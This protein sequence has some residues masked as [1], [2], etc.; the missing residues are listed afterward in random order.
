MFASLLSPPEPTQSPPLDFEVFSG[1]VLKPALK[2]TPRRDFVHFRVGFIEEAGADLSS[3]DSSDN[4][5]N[6]D[7]YNKPEDSLKRKRVTFGRELSPE[8]FDR[9]LPADTPLRRGST[10]YNHHNIAA[11]PYA[12]QS[13]C[14]SP[15]DPLPQPDFDDRDQ[16]ETLQPLSLCFDAESSDSDSPASSSLPDHTDE[17]SPNEE[18]AAV[19]LSASTDH[20]PVTSSKEMAEE[21]DT[22]VSL[23]DADIVNES[24]IAPPEVSTTRIR[25][26][27]SSEKPPSSEETLESN[28]LKTLV[29]AK[30]K[31][32]AKKT[33]KPMIIRKAQMKAPRGKGKK[34]GG[35]SKKSVQK[36]VNNERDG[37]S[38][39]PLL[40][41]IPELPE[42]VPTPPATTSGVFP[43]GKASKYLVKKVRTQASA[44]KVHFTFA[45]SVEGNLEEKDTERPPLCVEN[46]PAP[47]DMKGSN[48][49]S[50]SEDLPGSD[51]VDLAPQAEPVN[52]ECPPSLA[53]VEVMDQV[54]KPATSPVPS[55]EVEKKTKITK[56]RS[57]TRK[58]AARAPESS[59]RVTSKVTVDCVRLDEDADHVS[60]KPTAS[61][62]DPVQGAVAPSS[63]SNGLS[64]K[65]TTTSP[66]KPPL[67][68]ISTDR[69][70]SRRSSRIHQVSSLLSANPEQNPPAE[71]SSAPVPYLAEHSDSSMSDFCL[72]IDEALQ[73]PQQEKKVRRSMRL[74][75]DSGV[76]GLSWVEEIKGS[77][78]TGRRRSLSSVMRLEESSESSLDHTV[79]SPNKENLSNHHVPNLARRT[80]RRTLGTTTIQEGLLT[81]DTKRRRS[82]SS[83]KAPNTTATSDEVPHSALV[84][85]A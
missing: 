69:K 21:T 77:D 31:L 42:C 5:E 83:H 29:I 1:P 25:T 75:R 62:D 43:P 79:H 24:F 66:S 72:P 81:C 39:R 15:C 23:S 51:A 9:T 27:R 12:Q 82:I 2:K 22:S 56:R 7:I 20:E 33:R 4:G 38:K 78:P 57:S 37:I 41:P 19:N 74:R 67:G 84:P 68:C 8:L 52:S 18:E 10:P 47:E 40:S 71:M 17:P 49:G 36:P 80:R 11:T 61:I 73:Y 44:G 6:A 35:K 34:K 76:I 64:D 55:S 60:H 65:S 54:C 50:Q 70:K 26:L 46:V 3:Q 13:T 16:E 85:D 53:D 45:A 32:T 30:V 14:Q 58:Y 59:H 48:N 28:D 63:M